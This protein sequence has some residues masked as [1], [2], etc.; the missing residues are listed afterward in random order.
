MPLT[1]IWID[2]SHAK[3]FNLSPEH[4][5]TEKK[6]KHHEIRHHTHAIDQI[7]A[8]FHEHEFQKIIL[9]LVADA[10]Q[11]LLLGPGV[12][13]T[14]FQHFLDTRH[15]AIAKKVVACE[16]MDHPTDPQI[17]AFAKKYLI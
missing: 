4:L 1:A 8:Q 16:N 3:I 9:K 7:E 17:A 14:H 2:Q 5:T 13:K 6:L 11:I 12:A 15:P 10:E